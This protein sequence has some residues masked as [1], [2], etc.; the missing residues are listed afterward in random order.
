MGCSLF[1]RGNR[2][3]PRAILRVAG[4]IVLFALF[5]GGTLLFRKAQPTD[6]LATAIEFAKSGDATK[7]RQAMTSFRGF[8]DA[9][10]RWAP[11]VIAMTAG[12]DP[13]AREAATALLGETKVAEAVTPLSARLGAGVEPDDTVREALVRALREIADPRAVHPLADA[14]SREQEPDLAVAMSVAVFELA[15]AGQDA[16]L[17]S[18]GDVLARVMADEGAPRAAKR[19]ASDAM[20]AHVVL[21]ATCHDDAM[22]VTWWKEHR[23][24]VTWRPADH[25]LAPPT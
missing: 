22:A 23:D 8:P 20:R 2:F 19:D 17:R 12:P 14:A 5:L 9:K 10:A 25:K 4:F 13:I 7:Q 18:A 15:T 11:L 16:D 6:E 1:L 3:A 21:D 24:A